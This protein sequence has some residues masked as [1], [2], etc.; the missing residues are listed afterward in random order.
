MSKDLE[1]AAGSARHIAR[2]QKAQQLLLNGRSDQAL[3]I[4]QDLTRQFPDTARLWYE[5]GFAA[6]KQL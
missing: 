2:W 3:L 6:G 4:Y 5:L 1:S